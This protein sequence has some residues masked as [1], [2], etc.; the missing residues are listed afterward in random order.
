MVQRIVHVTHP[1]GRGSGHVI[2]PGLVLTSAHVVPDVPGA[3]VKV[4]SLA[5]L[6]TYTGT[7]VWRGT[8]GG[9]D[10]AALVEVA[11]ARLV[12]TPVRWGRIVT[13]VPG[14]GCQAWG[15]PDVAQRGGQAIESAQPAGT[16]NPGNRYL[17]D[18]YIMDI[19]T[20]PPRWE[21]KGSPWAGLS[22]AALVCDELVVGVVAT[23]PAHSAYARVEAV[24]AYVLHRDPGF[25]RLLARHGA[26]GPL[27]AVELQA[28]HLHERP[29][30][31]PAGLLRARR[32][33]V[34]FHGRQELMKDLTAWCLDGEDFAARLIHGPGGQ[35]KTRLAHELADRLSDPAGSHRWAAL[36]L[37]RDAPAEAL[38]AVAKVAVPLLVVVDYA[39]TRTGQLTALLDV[40]DRRDGT[41]PVRVLMLARTGGEWWHNLPSGSDS[42]GELLDTATATYLPPLIAEPDD[43]AAEY[44]LALTHLATAL[45]TVRGQGPVDWGTK[46]SAL[47]VPDLQGDEWQSALAVHM[48]A[49]ADLLDAAHPTVAAVR[50][51]G[52]VEDRLLEHEARYWNAAA[53]SHGLDGKSLQGEL[54]NL[55]AIAFTLTPA[56]TEDAA[57]LVKALPGLRDKD[58]ADRRQVVRWVTSLYPAEENR[59]WGQLQPDRLLERF[60]GLRL[61]ET[62]DLFTPYLEGIAPD[63][64]ERLLT[65]YARA[66]AQPA[67]N[68]ALDAKLTRLCTD[69]A[70]ELG[71]AAIEVATQVEAPRPL[72]DALHALTSDR[73]VPLQ[74]LQKLHNRLPDFSHRLAEYAAALSTR[75]VDLRRTLAEQRPDTYLPDLATSLNNQSVRL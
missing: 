23:D 73:D 24:P 1:G 58:E 4:F 20:Q 47:P 71:S 52:T 57:A 41:I 68:S 34:S 16:I 19:T 35:G 17:G 49:L 29:S 74:V 54:R 61:E 27:E 65:L 46:S 14:I 26:L 7:V 25:H 69:H 64:A 18:R 38:E 66:A 10:D 32:Q 22:G 70:Q 44:R 50:G 36:W 9:R 3:E 13:N 39:E 15:F 42:C 75:L 6:R 12:E 56:N 11:D 63:D 53:H 43:R 59:M 48:R 5:D 21:E 67:F 37:D 30:R 60:L 62:P 40:C 28:A 72:I 8:P 2:G 51:R 31:S 33:I 45:P 55:L